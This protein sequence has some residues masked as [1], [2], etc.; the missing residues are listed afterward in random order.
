MCSWLFIETSQYDTTQRGTALDPGAPTKQEQL[1]SLWT[2]RKQKHKRKK[3]RRIIRSLALTQVV[4][5]VASLVEG[6]GVE[7]EADDGEDDDGE[8]QQK[9]DVDQRSN[10]L[11]DRAHHNLKA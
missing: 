10:G 6:T 7:L 9:R 5:L 2:Q 1:D 3:A 11:A 4:Q 8:E